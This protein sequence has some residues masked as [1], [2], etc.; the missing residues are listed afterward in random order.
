MMSEEFIS[1]MAAAAVSIH[2]LYLALV[3]AGFP[4]GHALKLTALLISEQ[5]QALK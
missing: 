3:Q 4:E 5:M 1:P 2:E